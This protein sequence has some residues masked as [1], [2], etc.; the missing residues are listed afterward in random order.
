[1]SI[2]DFLIILSLVFFSAALAFYGR[3]NR[4][5][6]LFSMT[7]LALIA[8]IYSI[9]DG[10]A[11]VIL[12]FVLSVV[13]LICLVVAEIVVKESRKRLVLGGLSL[14][15]SAVA[16][17]PMLMFSAHVEYPELQGP[18]MVGVRSAEVFDAD[19][20][21]AWNAIDDGPRRMLVRV[22]YPAKSVPEG[23]SNARNTAAEGELAKA[24]GV[25]G[26]KPQKILSESL[27]KIKTNAYW[28]APSA[29]GSFPLLIFSHGYSGAINSNAMIMEQLASHGY[30]VI[31]MTH[32]GESAG[33]V[34]PNGDWV[35]LAPEVDELF[36]EHAATGLLDMFDQDLAT[37][38][39]W[40]INVF[41]QIRMVHERYPVR[42]D[43][44]RSVLDAL[45]QGNFTGDIAEILKNTDMKAIGYF[46]MSAGGGTAPAACHLDIRCTATAA[47]DGGL[48]IDFMRNQHLRLPALISDGGFPQRLAGQD[49]YYEPHDEFGLN[50]DIYRIVFPENGH[51]DF[52]DMAYVL[53]P[54]G[55]KLLPSS[56]L[57]LGPVNAEKTLLMQS[58]LVTAFFD[59]YLKEKSDSDFPESILSTK[60]VAEMA[61]PKPFREWAI[62]HS[63][64]K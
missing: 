2:I 64:N 29:A 63:K 14:L 18:H 40:V 31:S 45:E 51:L 42:I 10:R 46:G 5:F 37:R 4:P 41:S 61:D 17:L 28:D 50:P 27:A 3:P 1:M 16:A 24:Y 19:R 23:A 26:F 55:K 39:D 33:L 58:Q 8:S 36:K 7:I 48:G 20:G 60:T 32:P 38:N 59:I 49:L 13:F 62:L 9:L 57:V 21:N 30:V 56:L 11:V 6:V 35:P 44:F 53:S 43:D 25:E 34:F 54:I 12:A 15:L 52:T 47:L 22:W